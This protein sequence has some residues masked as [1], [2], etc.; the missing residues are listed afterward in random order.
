M[1]L[2]HIGSKEGIKE[3][4]KKKLKS[5]VAKKVLNDKKRYVENHQLSYDKSTHLIFKI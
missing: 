2:Q 3:P 1:K 5:W 4:T